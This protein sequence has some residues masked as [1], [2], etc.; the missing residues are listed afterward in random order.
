MR[1]LKIPAFPTA[2]YMELTKH[3]NIALAVILILFQGIALYAQTTKQEAKPEQLGTEIRKLEQKLYGTAGTATGND[4]TGIS[5]AERHEALVNLAHLRQLSGNVAGAAANWLEAVSINPRDDAALI[6]G[7][8]CLAAIG[9]WE[10]AASALRP[11]LDSYLQGK[12]MLQ[13]RFLDA[14][15][16][17]RIAAEGTASERESSKS[18]ALQSGVLQNDVSALATL[19][20]DPELAPLHPMIY[21]TLWQ[22][23]NG[24][25]RPS[26]TGSAGKGSG[27]EKWKIRLLDEYPQSPEARVA[28]AEKNAITISAVQSPLWLLFPGPETSGFIETAAETPPP[29]NGKENAPP[30]VVLQTGLFSREANARSQADALRKAGFTALVSAKKANGTERWVVTVPGGQNSAKTTDDLKKAGFDSFPVK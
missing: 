4:G 29:A 17:V 30:S 24:N 13:A 8:Y 6:T 10:L 27:A 25:S 12:S 22:I 5:A 3:K 14:F 15:L 28:A 2:R 26:E 1:S 18:G 19:A 21:Y 11:L 23:L 9:E 7:A 20:E 16:K